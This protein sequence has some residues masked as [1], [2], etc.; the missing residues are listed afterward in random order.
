[1]IIKEINGNLLEEFEKGTIDVLVHGCNCFNVMG[2]GIAAQIRWKYPSAFIVDGELNVGDYKKLGDYSM[3]IL[4]LKGKRTKVILNLYTQYEPGANFEYKAFIDSL[5][6]L[7]KDFKNANFIFGFPEIGCG[8]GGAKWP[9]VKELI[10]KYTKN[11]KVIIVHYDHGV[12]NV[13][14]T[15]ARLESE[16]QGF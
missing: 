15:R 12:K 8:I 7:N 3:A 2:A 11:L 16:I 13:G 9:Y 6:R 14:T 10:E 1:M 4:P 5:K